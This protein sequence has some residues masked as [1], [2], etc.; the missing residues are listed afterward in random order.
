MR[1]IFTLFLVFLTTASLG[2]A[3]AST[4]KIL[5]IIAGKDFRD[6]ELLVPKEIFKK[7]GF[8]LVVA[9]SSL[10]TARG[11]LGAEVTPDILLEAV[12]VDDYDAIVFIGGIG[13]SEYWNN[14][15]AHK[16]AQDADKKNKVLAAICFAPVTLANAGVLSKKKAT[17]WAS[18]A[19]KLIQVGAVYTASAVEIDGNIIT[20]NSPSAAPEF[21]WAIVD[22][23]K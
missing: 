5:A 10:S 16:L 18:E 21:A 7:S 8:K 13:A 17:V 6:E 12:D 23:L 11:M 15:F 4:N 22:K 9:S 1:I 19:N 20:A 2:K 3:E 14:P